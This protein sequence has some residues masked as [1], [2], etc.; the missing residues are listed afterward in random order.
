MPSSMSSSGHSSSRP[1]NAAA[2]HVGIC[3]RAV[4]VTSLV[5]QSSKQTVH[6]RTCGAHPP[7]SLSLC[8]PEGQ[9]IN[10]QLLYSDGGPDHSRPDSTAHP[11]PSRAEWRF[12][13]R[14]ERALSTSLSQRWRLSAE[15]RRI[16]TPVHLVGHE[17]IGLRQLRSRICHD[18]AV[19]PAHPSASET[20]L[21]SEGVEFFVLGNLLIRGVHAT[22][23]YTRYPGWD[24][25][26]TNPATGR[27]CRIQVKARLATDF[28]GGFPIKNFDAEFVV[29]VALNRG[30]RYRK[31]K[32]IAEGQ[33]GVQE[34]EFFI[35]PMTVVSA[36]A[37][38]APQWGASVKI[39]VRRRIENW[40][41]YRSAWP[42][43]SEYLQLPSSTP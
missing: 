2:S 21:H 1:K 5:C 9:W 23:A 7:R 11:P 36:V 28:D 4:T 26:A 10:G 35:L 29:L 15:R 8:S 18:S 31:A 33:D 14:A 24:L 22:K 16:G 20:N 32:L 3:V 17:V 43:I 39:Y 25:L 34:P 42:Q 40:E 12:R 19:K 27:T 6:L 41:Q 13:T 30:Y 38:T 37:E